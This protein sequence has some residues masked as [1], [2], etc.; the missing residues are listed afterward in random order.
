MSNTQ[1]ALEALTS[2]SKRPKIHD[3]QMVTKLPK[4]VKELVKEYGQNRGDSEG[5]V[6]RLALAEFFERRGYNV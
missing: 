1:K 5:A 2:G 4:A 3:A 6:V